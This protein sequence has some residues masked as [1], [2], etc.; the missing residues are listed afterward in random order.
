MNLQKYPKS[1]EEKNQF[2]RI[3]V[4]SISLR[5]MIQPDMVFGPSQW[6]AKQK[7][8]KYFLKNMKNEKQMTK[9]KSRIM[10]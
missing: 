6:G 8:W 5:L 10:G 3:I 9:I 1:E 7:C 4:L 2:S